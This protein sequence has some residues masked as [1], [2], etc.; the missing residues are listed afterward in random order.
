MKYFI[1]TLALVFTA[2]N[3]K[4]SGKID[5]RPKIGVDPTWSPLNFGAQTPYVNGFVDE[6]LRDIADE[7]DIEFNKIRVNPGDLLS[8]LDEGVYDA[9]LTSLPPYTFNVAKYDFSKNFLATGP[10]FIVPKEAGYK[11]LSELHHQAVG[12]IEH[13]PAIEILRK[14]SNLFVRS[15][16]STPDLL[17]AIVEGEIAGALL[18]RVPA[19]AYVPDLY[20]EKLKIVSMPLTDQGL[21]LITLKKSQEEF[22]E[23]FDGVLRYLK[24]KKKID[25][26]LKKWSLSLTEG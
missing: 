18:A 10:V 24:R 19:A 7:L 14:Y 22:L 3:P 23:S 20:Q 12:I 2:C 26:L 8:G 1:L 17:N 13:S 5:A 9:V 11:K 25:D 21:Q 6:L 15:Y 4:E 16:V